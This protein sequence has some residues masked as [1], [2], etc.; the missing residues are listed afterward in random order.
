MQ[1][2]VV[3]REIG[4]KTLR[5]ETGKLAK[6]AAGS[7]LI[8]LGDTVILTAVTTSPGRPGID[9]FPLTVDYRE[10]TYAAGKY[11]GG[12]KKREG[13]PSTKEILTMRL[14]D[15]PIRPLFPKGF[16]NEVQVQTIVMAY[17]RE[18]DP[19]VLSMVGAS[20]A[21][22][23]SDL[24]FQGP[25]GAVR[26]GRV[27]EKLILFPTMQEL[28][29]SDMDLVVAGH[30]EEVCMI[31]GFGKEIPEDEMYEA[32]LFAHRGI[33]TLIEMQRELRQA[34]GKGDPVLPAAPDTTL[35]D[36]VVARY[37]EEAK[38][39]KQTPGKLAKAEAFQAVSAKILADFVQPL[40]ED[41]SKTN[42]GKVKEAIHK[43]EERI[44]RDLI[45]TG[46]RSDG[47]PVG[48]IR[49]LFSEVAVLPRTH[50]S[51]LFQRGETQALVVA[52]LGGAGDE[53]MVDGLDD[54]FHE[55]FMLHYNFPP[56]S[57]GECRPI[58]GPGRREIGHGAL[59]ERSLKPVV[60][61]SDKFP[62][63]IRLVSEILESNGSSSMA[64]V[65]AGTLALMDAG[66][67]IANPVAGISIG[68][69]REPNAYTLL[70]DI[71]GDEDHFG[72]MDFK[73]AGSQ[74]GITGIQLDLKIAGIS[75][76]IIRETL[77]RAREA[78]INILRHM[79]STLK[80]PNKELS[81]YAP[82]VIQLT[83]D[84]EKIGAVIGPGGKTIRALQE[85][86]KTDI[87]IVDDG[88]VTICGK[89]QALVEECR[90]RIEAMTEV[91]QVG[92]IYKGKVASITDFGAFVE[93]VPG[94]DG[95]VHISELDH[96]YVN[97]VTDVCKIGDPMEVIVIGIDDHDRVKLSRKALM[98]KDESAIDQ[99]ER[100]PREP[101]RERSDRDGG[102]RDRPERPRGDR[103]ERGGGDRGERGGGDRGQR[104]RGQQR[105]RGHQREVAPEDRG[106]R[107]D[108]DRGRD[109]RDRIERDR[110][111]EERERGERDRGERDRGE[112]AE[113]GG[114]DDR[115]DRDR[116]DRDRGDR[117][118]GMDRGGDR[119][120]DRGRGDRYERGR[121][122]R[123]RGDRGGRDDRGGRGRDDDRG[124]DR[125]RD[126]D[127]YDD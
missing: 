50:G 11:P 87:N 96:G 30:Y 23:V 111:R 36:A 117:D 56:F 55:K 102:D 57:V 84:R 118:R 34:V 7:V 81:P 93:L 99:G 69:V 22:I 109:D 88:T 24:P 46:T 108:R 66:V 3:E 115:G 79:L 95:L 33:R 10:R 48:D 51:A 26:V 12:F 18:N 125:D 83:I 27:D 78:R 68:L 76:E 14:T 28:A 110:L 45:L 37:Y 67:K 92:R 105:D 4:G 52:T 86:T 90:N 94:R 112:R 124:R 65:C 89:D 107:H 5:V 97:K 100:P 9:F 1:A 127:R 114:R 126:F 54:Q 77:T 123:D 62:Y 16:T 70:T 40:P 72:D 58:R 61:G 64:T 82:R 19:D 25:I 103:P 2:I 42:E 80:R 63:T 49:E 38:A 60:P 75:E 71:I 47:R 13:A 15:R 21:L 8:R 43:L 44:V 122:D 35:L 101:R 41:A 98:E 31:E 73:V 74:I 91:I 106:V 121:G 104:D 17:D 6:Q 113:R 119:G 29:H 32:I 116:G 53:Q 85:E 20:A 120:G 59:A 39:A